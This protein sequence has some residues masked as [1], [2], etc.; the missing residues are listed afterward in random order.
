MSEEMVVG[1]EQVTAEEIIKAP[2]PTTL[3]QRSSTANTLANLNTP[4]TAEN[5]LLPEQLHIAAFAEHGQVTFTSVKKT[6]QVLGD[7]AVIAAVKSAAIMLGLFGCPFA[8]VKTN[9]NIGAKN[10]ARDSGIYNADGTINTAR[11]QKLREYA[12]M[13]NGVEVISESRLNEFLQ[14]ARAQ[15]TRSDPIN[16]GK[17][18]SN[19]E[20]ADCYAKFCSS[21]KKTADNKYEP[22]IAIT[23][24]RQFYED[25]AVVVQMVK[26][27]QLP[28]AKPR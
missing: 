5:V 22:C 13:Q 11:W 16:V 14:W 2:Q 1:N 27:K 25:T 18:A 19:A 8:K 24:L 21:W 20:W 3:M 12:E 17:I 23:I 6:L 7:N 9:I 4:A 10:H 28:A 15:D 26:D